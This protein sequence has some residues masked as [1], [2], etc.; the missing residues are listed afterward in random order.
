MKQKELKRR[1]IMDSIARID[2]FLINFNPERDTKE[3]AIRLARLDKLMENFEDIQGEY[4]TFDDSNEFVKSNMSIRA[5]V[6]EQ[7]FRV[8]GGLTSLQP[9][10]AAVPTPTAVPSAPAVSHSIGVKLPTITLPQFDGDLNDWLTFHDSFSSLIHSSGDIPCIQK[11]QYL[12]SALKG[13]ALK[14]IESLT[15]TAAN[16]SV[17]WQSL[18]N[19][20]SNKYLLKKK[21]LQAITFPPKSLSKSASNSVSL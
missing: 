20:Y 1:N 18:L 21:H 16:Y 19:R 10:P 8:K 3:V 7:Y 14:L 9:P 17:A 13:D 4:E 5:K 15:I 2:E 12:R 11:F 6:E